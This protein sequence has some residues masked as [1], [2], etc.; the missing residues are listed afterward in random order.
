MGISLN[1]AKKVRFP[2]INGLFSELL[3]ELLVKIQLIEIEI[4]S[5]C[6]FFEIEWQKCW[7][8]I[9]TVFL[10]VN[11][12]R[13]KKFPS[14]FRNLSNALFLVIRIV[15]WHIF[16]KICVILKSFLRSKS[17]LF[18]CVRV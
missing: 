6:Q 18:C 11:L 4:Y 7:F 9:G 8:F 14:L 17:L 10:A 3:W 2:T 5:F 12:I 16:W 1:G 15:I 13:N